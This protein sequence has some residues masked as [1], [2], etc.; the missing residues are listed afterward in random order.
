[1]FQRLGLDLLQVNDDGSATVHATAEKMDKLL[2]ASESL[3]EVG[4]REQSRWAT[5]DTFGVIPP[6]LRVDETWLDDLSVREV[7]DAVL[8]L[9]PLLTRAEIDEVVRAVASFLKHDLGEKLTGTGTDFSGRQWF[10]GRVAKQSLRAIAKHFY[11]VQ[12]VHPP[13]LSLAPRA[14]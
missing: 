9:Q 14:R 5:I 4:T 10:R 7:A 8:E 13:L 12:S 6:S 3:D 2:L 1:M 11:S